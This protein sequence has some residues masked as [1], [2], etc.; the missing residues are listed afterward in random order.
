MHVWLDSLNVRI[1]AVAFAEELKSVDPANPAVRVDN[2]K[3]VSARLQAISNKLKDSLIPVK[4]SQLF[5]F[6]DAYQYFEKRYG[7]NGVG[8]I[9]VSPDK[10]GVDMAPALLS[11]NPLYN[12]LSHGTG[13]LK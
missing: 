4:S 1:T 12:S 3:N 9:T 6:H 10:N 11:K 8:S 5:V 13:V 2:A 7:L